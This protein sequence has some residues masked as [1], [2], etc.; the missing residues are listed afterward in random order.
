MVEKEP[1]FLGRGEG[2]GRW[3][4]G[5]VIDTLSN[6][7]YQS[8]SHFYFLWLVAC[9]CS[10]PNSLQAYDR[11]NVACAHSS[12]VPASD[13]RPKSGAREPSSI[14]DK[15]P[16]HRFLCQLATLR[17]QCEAPT[18]P[19]YIRVRTASHPCR[20]SCLHTSNY[21]HDF[22]VISTT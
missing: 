3:H 6:Q 17:A 1:H 12:A 21:L 9:L 11:F 20:S 16:H 22:A 8:M 14:R 7:H 13:S 10:N 4:S 18:T 5:A 15:R 19:S 2:R